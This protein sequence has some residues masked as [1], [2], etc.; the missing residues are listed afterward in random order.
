MVTDVLSSIPGIVRPR[1]EARRVWGLIFVIV[2]VEPSHFVVLYGL[3]FWTYSAAA[4]VAGNLNVAYS[5]GMIDGRGIGLR[6][7]QEIERQRQAQRGG[8]SFGD[9]L[10]KNAGGGA[11]GQP[12][13]DKP[14]AMKGNDNGQG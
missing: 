12:H 7:Q 2:R 14:V 9:F 10:D 8:M 3:W 11:I 13:A 1:Y 6:E 4:V 5:L